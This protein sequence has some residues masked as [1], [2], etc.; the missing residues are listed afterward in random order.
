MR[1]AAAGLAAL[2]LL[3]GVRRG[4]RGAAPARTRLSRSE[5]ATL[6]QNVGWPATEIDRATRIA[7]RESGGDPRAHLVVTDPKPGFGREDSRGL[8]QINVLAWTEYASRDLYD[9]ATNARTALE[10][11]RRLGWKPWRLSSQKEQ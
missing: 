1:R 2:L 6:L 7:L 4:A 11:W 3:A 8:F 10:I 5:L 9:A